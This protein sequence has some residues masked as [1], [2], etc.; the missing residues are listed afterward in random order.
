MDQIPPDLFS[1]DYHD[2]LTWHITWDQW[3]TPNNWSPSFL[4]KA[5][6]GFFLCIF[7]SLTCLKKPVFSK[8]DLLGWKVP[9][10]LYW[11]LLTSRGTSQVVLGSSDLWKVPA[12]QSLFLKSQKIP[13]LLYIG[14]GPESRPF[15]YT[16]M[17]QTRKTTLALL[18]PQ[19]GWHQQA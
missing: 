12:S 19:L 3:W 5:L 10:R 8:W 4:R 7:S 13:A 16:N 14:K 15:S 6:P 11:D 1:L 9:A 18:W 2:L 17:S